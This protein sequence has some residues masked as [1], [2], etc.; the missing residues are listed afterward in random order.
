MD[1]AINTALGSVARDRA[2]AASRRKFADS[3]SRV[4]QVESAITGSGPGSHAAVAVRSRAGALDTICTA[5]SSRRADVHLQ[6]AI[7]RDGRDD[8]GEVAA[9]L[10]EIAVG[11]Q[12]HIAGLKTR[13]L[14]RR[15]R[16][17]PHDFH[18]RAARVASR[19]FVDAKISPL[20]L[21]RRRI[22]RVVVGVDRDSDSIARIVVRDGI[23]RA[24]TVTI[25]W[26]P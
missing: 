22:N 10:S 14:G 8:P 19:L 3:Q 18:P 25:A 6:Y 26:I 4:A 20:R 7:A 17:D 15:T 5:P 23:A 21:V 9:L 1:R 11:R 12:N 16:I 24:I 2:D 13:L